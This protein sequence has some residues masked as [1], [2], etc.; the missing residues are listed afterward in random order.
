MRIQIRNTDTL[1]VG[2]HE[3]H[4]EHPD[5]QADREP[6]HQQDHPADR[7][8]QAAKDGAHHQHLLQQQVGRE[9]FFLFLM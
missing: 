9:P 3:V 1:D 5:G 4:D 8:P 6:Q 7:R 2:G